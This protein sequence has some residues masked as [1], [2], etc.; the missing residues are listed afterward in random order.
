LVAAHRQLRGR[1][2]AQPARS[3]L[4]RTYG[5]TC[6]I[7]SRQAHRSPRPQVKLLALR[8]VE[9]RRR[10]ASPR[11]ALFLLRMSPSRSKTMLPR[12]RLHVGSPRHRHSCA[13]P[14]GSAN[15]MG[16]CKRCGQPKR[17]WDLVDKVRP[18][19]RGE[20]RAIVTPQGRSTAM[21][22]SDSGNSRASMFLDRRSLRGDRR[23]ISRSGRRDNDPSPQ[24]S[25]CGLTLVGGLHGS[26]QD[27]LAALRSE[28]S[29]LRH[30]QQRLAFGK[31]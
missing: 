4:L 9:R 10:P 29:Q 15:V 14:A 1:S 11:L 20:I 19:G 25:Y 24:C 13:L 28:V 23:A 30:L 21:G 16:I 18:F 22:S 31:M 2:W 3:C 6:P 5:P 26:D 12:V 7:S 17:A 27:C 8:V